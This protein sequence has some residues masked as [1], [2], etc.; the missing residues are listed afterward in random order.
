[1]TITKNFSAPIGS[2]LSKFVASNALKE[3]HGRGGKLTIIVGVPEMKEQRSRL[4]PDVE[5]LTGLEWLKRANDSEKDLIVVGELRDYTRRRI[6]A[7]L[8]AVP[9]DVWTLNAPVSLEIP[10][11]HPCNGFAHPTTFRH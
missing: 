10:R 8:Q 2:G 11:I 3:V 4:L 5:V 1:M 9:C 7:T 6:T